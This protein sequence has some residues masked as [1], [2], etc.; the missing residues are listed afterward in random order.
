MQFSIGGQADGNIFA[1]PS[2]T[3]IPPAGQYRILD[4]CACS[5]NSFLN[6]MLLNTASVMTCD[7][8]LN[9]ET[10]ETIYKQMQV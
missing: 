6:I 3:L 10:I 5:R 4:Y 9:G 7:T 2:M 8:L 1:D